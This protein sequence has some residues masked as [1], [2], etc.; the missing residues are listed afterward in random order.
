MDCRMPGFPVLHQLPEPT[1]THVHWVSD[2]IQPSHPLSSPSPPAFNLSQHQGL[3]QWVSSLHQVAKILEFQ[4]QHQFFQGTFRADFLWNWLVGFPC[5]PRA[6]LILLC[7]VLFMCKGTSQ[8]LFIINWKFMASPRWT[9]LSMPF[10]QQHF[11][12]M[13]LCQSVCNSLTISSFDRYIY[14]GDLWSVISEVTIVI[15][16]GHPEP[17]PYEIANLTLWYSNCSTNQSFPRISPPI[18]TSLF[19]KT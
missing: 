5:S 18:W 9:N 10:F 13:S 15:V 4:L 11:V 3:F 17:C 14:Y 7:V 12:L 1:E 6:Y 8:I 16:L 2:A 19:P